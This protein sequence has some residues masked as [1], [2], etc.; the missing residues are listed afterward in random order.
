MQ[1]KNFLCPACSSMVL[2]TAHHPRRK[3]CF[4]RSHNS[5]RF[6]S[7][8]F[9]DSFPLLSCLPHELQSWGAASSL[10]T[11]KQL[12]R[13]EVLP[14][15][16]HCIM[17]L[18]PTVEPEFQHLLYGARSHNSHCRTVVPLTSQS[19]RPPPQPQG[20]SR[21]TQKLGRL[22]VPTGNPTGS[23]AV[24]W[25]KTPHFPDRLPSLT[26]PPVALCYEVHN[27]FVHG[28]P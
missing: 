4:M 21:S 23:S 20:T 1:K 7:S 25:E 8:T 12:M 17:A 2:G 22:R 14:E 16:R 27:A 28:H 15:G 3:G 24:F 11:R 10:Q 9:S 6:Q 5:G 13:T 18:G 19:M 26:F